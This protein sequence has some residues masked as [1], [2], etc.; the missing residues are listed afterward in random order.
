[1]QLPRPTNLWL[2]HVK[3]VSVLVEVIEV[4]N[5]VPCEAAKEGGGWS[6]NSQ[7]LK[8]PGDTDSVHFAPMVRQ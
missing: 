8:V 5:L 4:L 3:C 1:V 2:Y 7:M 6:A